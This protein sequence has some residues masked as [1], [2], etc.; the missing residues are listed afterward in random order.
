MTH[1]H[2]TTKHDVTNREAILETE[3]D[4]KDALLIVSITAN[5]FLLTL[6][7]ASQAG[8]S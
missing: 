1:H 3:K 6:W 7:V 8:I 5:L 2:S 4:F